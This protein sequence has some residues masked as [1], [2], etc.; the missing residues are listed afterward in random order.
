MV[1]HMVKGFT[2]RISQNIKCFIVIG[3]SAAHPESLHE[4]TVS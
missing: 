3:S 2:E 4:I 1:Y